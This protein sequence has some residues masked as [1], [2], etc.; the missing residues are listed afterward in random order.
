MLQ[1]PKEESFE[2]VPLGEIIQ[3]YLQQPGMMHSILQNCN[4]ESNEGIVE[5]YRDGTFYKERFCEDGDLDLV[6]P[7]I[8]YSD[9]WEPSNPLGS[10]KGLHKMCGFYL[11]FLCIPRKHQSRLC[12][13]LLVALAKSLD[14]GKYGIDAVQ[15]IIVRNLQS[16]YDNGIPINSP[17]E[18]VGLVRPKLF[19]VVGD[20]LGLHTMLG[21]ACGFTAN[22]P[23]RTC[24][25][26]R[27]D[28]QKQE[29][30][31][32]S[33]LRTRESFA[34]DAEIDDVSRTGVSRNCI[35]NDLGYFHV[36]DNVA[37]DI[38]HD[39]L[40]GVLPMEVKLVMKVLI[41]RKEFSLL[42][43]NSRI[44]SFSYGFT[45]KQNC[46]TQ[47]TVHGLS[48]P[49]GSSGQKAAQMQ[50]LFLY[51]P[52]IIGDKVNRDCD[53]WELLLILMDIYKLV[54]A[55][56]ISVQA[57]FLLKALIRDHHFIFK[58][59][60]PDI[61][62]TPKQHHLVH[63]PRAIRLL[64][65]LGQ[66][67]AM[68]FEGKHKSL[69]RFAKSA[70]NFIRIDK[71][72][73]KMH[74]I[75]QSHE[76]LIKQNVEQKGTEVY[77]QTV[78]PVTTLANAEEIC[79]NLKCGLDSDVIVANIV[80]VNGYKFRRSTAVLICWNEEFPEFGEI[81]DIVIVDSNIRFILRPLETL[82]FERHYHSYAVRKTPDVAVIVKS[83]DDLGD[84]RP[85]HAVKSYDVEDSNLY[86]PVRYQLS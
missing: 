44:S 4:K 79:A 13:I 86:V 25:S 19:Q 77:N 54:V 48:N 68:R 1:L 8:L 10:K 14:I 9:D 36:V 46:P 64:G 52:L 74:Q 38:M 43:L 75:A 41:D 66:Y 67:S 32:T 29:T 22:Y 24:K 83:V 34:Q 35:L 27:V 56:S 60:F 17:G 76:F 49:K 84:H 62:L 28:C 23:C 7:V 15:R 58:Q 61:P 26:P 45:D 55:P 50:C 42:E 2:L 40:E 53:H 72:V 21:F 69:K 51:L 5:S 65:P 78:V 30:E 20:N 63:Y 59:L 3:V 73:A 82:H 71:T 57:T 39:L 6:L 33:L 70:N 81:Q 18:F 37:M 85:V 12:N 80:E 47:F 31:D 16:I 11:S